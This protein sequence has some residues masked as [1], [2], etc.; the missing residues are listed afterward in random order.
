VT[1]GDGMAHL[2]ER[3]GIIADRD[4]GIIVFARGSS[5]SFFRPDFDTTGDLYLTELVNA[6]RSATWAP[7]WDR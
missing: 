4:P 5:Q 6:K 7:T 1:D 3:E 2:V